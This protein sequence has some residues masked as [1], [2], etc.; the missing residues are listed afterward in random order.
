MD[1]DL[2]RHLDRADRYS[3]EDGE[4]D[5]LVY[6]WVHA[7]HVPPDAMPPLPAMMCAWCENDIMDVD[8]FIERCDE[9]IARKARRVEG[10]KEAVER[11]ID[12]AK[13]PRKIT[14]DDIWGG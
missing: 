7:G 11:T 5:G 10:V 1:H 8:A 3:V 2:D 12:E 13:K 14:V 4:A 6:C 9:I